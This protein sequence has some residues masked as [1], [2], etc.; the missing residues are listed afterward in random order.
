MGMT[1]M[2]GSYQGRDYSTMVDNFEKFRHQTSHSVGDEGCWY[3]TGIFDNAEA[4]Y[5]GALLIFD[6]E[7]TL[8]CA[9]ICDTVE[10][11][12]ESALRKE[13]TALYGDYL[14]EQEGTKALSGRPL[15][16]VSVEAEDAGL[17]L[18]E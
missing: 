4:C 11:L 5:P 8:V 3:E 16:D 13:A 7:D 6:N 2:G 10:D 1:C 17:G 15:P 9:R 12:S 14:K 18:G